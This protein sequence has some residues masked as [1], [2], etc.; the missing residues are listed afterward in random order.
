M[1]F[2]VA[3]GSMTAENFP[4]RLMVDELRAEILDGTRPPGSRMA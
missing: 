1:Q 3:S 4:Y 2:L